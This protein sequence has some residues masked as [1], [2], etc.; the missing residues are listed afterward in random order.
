[1]RTEQ[2]MYSLILNTARND[3]RIKAV[4]MNG[5]R[6]NKN[7]P[8][9]IFQDYDIVYVADETKSFIE[10]KDWINLF[11]E[12]LYMQYPDEN[13][14]FPSDK[15]NSYGWLVQFKD[16]NRI[17][18]TVQT[19]NYA[20]EHIKDDTLCKIL[21]DKENILPRIEPATD[22]GYWVTKPSKEQYLAVCNE[23]WWCTNNI[24]KGLWRKEFTYVQDMA[25]SYVRTELITML[26]WKAGIITDW[27]ISTGKSSKYLYRWLPEEYQTLM[28]TYFGCNI[29]D[30]WKA[31]FTM[32][33]LF[34]DVAQYTG[35]KLGYRY[36]KEEGAA[37]L[38]YLEDTYNLQLLQEEIIKK[39]N[40]IYAL[41]EYLVKFKDN[42]MDKD[43]MLEILEKL[44]II[45]SP[46]TEDT[47]LEL[48]DF[49][50]GVCNPALALF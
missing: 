40:D 18:L 17:D 37:A 2:E 30:A 44:K 11:G 28:E 43:T 7:V 39:Q 49:V 19:V 26:D 42:G 50:T 25:N 47:I 6:T 35:K 1:M 16:G 5:S 21:L 38:H 3:S 33:S 22:R 27:S 12:I 31:V 32:C 13:P 46:G 10:D 29:A 4:Y 14:Y 45:K 15:E 20:I 8:E 23:F 34:K 9:D 36:N 48:V 41:R 24:A